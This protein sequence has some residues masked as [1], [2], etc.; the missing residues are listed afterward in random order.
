MRRFTRM[1]LDRLTK[2]ATSAD[3]YTARS[4]LGYLLCTLRYSEDPEDRE[5]LVSF[6]RRAEP[7]AALAAILVMRS[8]VSP[9][10]GR[11]GELPEHDYDPV[12]LEALDP[13]RPRV[14]RAAMHPAG[15][16]DA[17]RTRL[18]EVLASPDTDPDLRDTI[19]GH[20]WDKHGGKAAADWL[21]GRLRSPDRNV[22]KNALD[23]LVHRYFGGEI[24]KR[25]LEAVAD[26]DPE[27]RVLVLLR[28]ES[29]LT[30]KKSRAAV[31]A[32]AK[33]Y[34]KSP[35]EEERNAAQA[36]FDDE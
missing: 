3:P 21:I 13:A 32:A 8:G 31:L 16:G 28:M 19:A 35:I 4:L 6:F 36:L 25:M 23:E 20:L 9:S 24:A 26:R 18:S 34:L 5:L 10:H 2:V 17:V 12:Y 7:A 11:W 14:F 22:F 27:D 1:N 29:F 30:S 15:L 33:P